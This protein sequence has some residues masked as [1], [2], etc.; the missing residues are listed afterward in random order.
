MATANN[1]T[2]DNLKARAHALGLE[3]IRDDA[4]Y[5]EPNAV[6]YYLLD[7]ERRTLVA[8][9]L[10]SE[11]GIAIELR[12]RE[13]DAEDDK[14]VA[15]DLRQRVAALG[16]ELW[17]DGDKYLVLE[18]HDD[19]RSPT[20]VFIHRAASDDELTDWLEHR[21]TREADAD[22]D[23]GATDRPAVTIFDGDVVQIVEGLA[24]IASAFD[25]QELDQD[26][27]CLVS[28]LRRLSDD[29]YAALGEAPRPV[30][31]ALKGVADVRQ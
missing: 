11:E 13:R 15:A 30:I 27:G 7:R 14:R 12:E 26:T 9:N 1:S 5:A 31:A 4:S 16:L 28:A 3:L 29:L 17:I 21:E 19:D 10:G 24:G 25:K 8:G 20:A 18:R 6:E 23:A 22:S 2:L